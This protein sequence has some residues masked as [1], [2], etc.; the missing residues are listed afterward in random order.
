MSEKLFSTI[1][2]EG[3][4]EFIPYV[5]SSVSFYEPAPPIPFEEPQRPDPSP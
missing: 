3:E 1:G 4:D 2:F 5:G